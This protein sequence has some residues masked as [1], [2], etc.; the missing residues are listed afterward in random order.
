MSLV[1]VFKKS[2]K[3]LSRYR[4]D[5]LS[6]YYLKLNFRNRNKIKKLKD[7]HRG[8]QCIIMATGPSL[9]SIDISSI[10]DHRYVFGLNRAYLKRACFKYYVCS[11]YTF[12]NH[13]RDEIM[14][15]KADLFIF[16]TIFPMIN[17]V[18][19]IYLQL[20]NKKKSTINYI[21]PNLLEQIDWGPTCLLDFAIP[22]ALW[23]GFTEIVLLGADYSLKDYNW[24][25][26]S[27]NEKRPTWP[28]EKRIQEMLLAHKK[29]Y[30]LKEYLTRFKP[31][32]RIINCSPLSELKMF[33][34]YLL[35]D[36]IKDSCI[37]KK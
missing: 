1:R 17:S 36:I 16:N 19:A 35:E 29:F 32:T 21:E 28:E 13:Y 27:Q 33:D 26:Q 18:N 2:K 11:S 7:I 15:V 3:K 34:K 4:K 31:D 9:N 25:Y 12:F 20:V 10:K 14:N 5:A 37:K 8:K 6:L 22:A 30:L 23:M 24:F